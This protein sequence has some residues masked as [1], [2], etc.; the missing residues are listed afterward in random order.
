MTWHFLLFA[1]VPFVF[2]YMDISRP[3]SNIRCIWRMYVD[4]K[5]CCA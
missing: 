5:A 1:L 3:S 2:R 4:F